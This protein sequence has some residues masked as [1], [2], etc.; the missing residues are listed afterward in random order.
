MIDIVPILSTIVCN[1]ML[2]LF[3]R[4][5]TLRQLLS[6]F[7]SRPS[8]K[9]YL[10]EIARLTGEPLGAVQ[11][12]LAALEKGGMLGS[13]RVGPLKYYSLRQDYPYREELQSLVAKESRRVLLEKNLRSIMRVLKEKYHPDK[14]ILF[15]SY[16]GGKISPESDLDLLIIK[17]NVPKRYWDRI[18]EIA[19]LLMGSEVGIDYTVWTPVEWKKGAQENQFMRQEILSKGKMLY[20][21][22]A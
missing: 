6:L 10:R 1:N 8:D 15:G 2:N 5:R 16:A 14:V 21:K 17:E 22:T 12:Q 13:Q 11:R 20:D 3:V 9:F 18:K 4:S 7:F 19:P